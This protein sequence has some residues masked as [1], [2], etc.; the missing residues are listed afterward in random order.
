MPEKLQRSR[1]QRQ[2]RWLARIVHSDAFVRDEVAQQTGPGF[3]AW[4]VTDKTSADT[5]RNLMLKQMAKKW[6]IWMLVGTP[7]MVAAIIPGC[8]LLP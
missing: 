8:P 3:V 6:R 5:R 7:V 4:I 2:S 1:G